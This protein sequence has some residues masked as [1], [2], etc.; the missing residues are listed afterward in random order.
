MNA[1]D[2]ELKAERRR[3]LIGRAVIVVFGLL[4]LAYAVADVTYRMQMR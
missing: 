3:K 4:A 2:D 1:P